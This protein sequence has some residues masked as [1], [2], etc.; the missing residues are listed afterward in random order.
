MIKV[1]C[2]Q[3]DRRYAVK[4]ALIGRRVK[5][6][7]C[8]TPI[9]ITENADSGLD[10]P[11]PNKSAG[12][13]AE[14]TS[15]L[16]GLAALEGTPAKR[17]QK[18]SHQVATALGPSRSTGLNNVFAL[19][20]LVPLPWKIGIL[21]LPVVCALALV[22]LPKLHDTWEQENGP[23]LV[24][25]HEAAKGLARAGEFDAATR[26]WEQLFEL[27]GDRTLSGDRM[28]VLLN[29]ARSA[30]ELA[31]AQK[32]EATRGPELLELSELA[33]AL[34]AE[35][36]FAEAQERCDA[37][38]AIL[39]PLGR[40][41]DGLADLSRRLE[42]VRTELAKT[43]TKALEDELETIVEHARIGV[44]EDRFA[45]A[46]EH[47]DQLDA[48]L[49]K[50]RVPAEVQ[51]RVQLGIEHTRSEL[52]GMALTHLHDLPNRQ[53]DAQ[54]RALAAARRPKAITTQNAPE[55]FETRFGESVREAKATKDKRDDAALAEV[56]LA[57]LNEGM[58][59]PRGARSGWFGLAGRTPPP[60][61]VVICENAYALGRSHV[62]GWPHAVEALRRLELLAPQRRLDCRLEAI[63]VAKKH[64]LGF[65]EGGPTSGQMIDLYLSLGSEHMS[66]RKPES[67]LEAFKEANRI[68]RQAGDGPFAL[69]T[70]RRT[71]ARAMIQDRQR[72]AE[73][74]EALDKDPI[75]Q[76]ALRELTTL[77]LFG[78][79][80]PQDALPYAQKLAD[81]SDHLELKKHASLA[82][83]GLSKLGFDELEAL[84]GWYTQRGTDKDNPNRVAMLMRAKL[85]HE[86]FLSVYL[87]RD[88]TRK[89]I[90]QAKRQ[91]ERHLVGLNVGMKLARRL[92]KKLRGGDP[93]MRDDPRI[94]LAIDRGVAYLYAV[95][96]QETH[97][98]KKA[99]ASDHTFG[100]YTALVAYALMMADEDPNDRPEL[101][102][103]IEWLFAMKMKG[104]YAVCFR[105]HLWETLPQ[106]KAAETV[107]RGDLQVLRQIENKQGTFH[108]Y[109]RRATSYDLS[110]TLAG[111]LAFWL[112]ETNGLKVSDLPWRRLV[113]HLAEYQNDD[114]GWGYQPYNPES[115]ATRGGMTSAALT[116]MLMALDQNHL[117]HYEDLQTEV[118]ASID[119]G[120][121]WLDE[122]F[123]P[124]HSPGGGPAN[125]YLATLQHV[126]LLSGRNTF[127]EQDW[128]ATGAEHLIGVQSTDGSWG[129]VAETAFAVVFLAR[130]GNFYDSHYDQYTSG[131]MTEDVKGGPT[132]MPA[133][134]KKKKTP[135]KESEADAPKDTPPG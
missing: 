43:W 10:S 39:R 16:D 12:A 81:A 29:E 56:L 23:R 15:F 109:L 36:R 48:A 87:Q 115:S 14:A 63:E 37:F 100:G 40:R 51:Q 110:T 135:P 34:L 130:G 122:N 5:C 67:A 73:L 112:G 69:I 102:R 117:K 58:A 82:A 19:W 57:S 64:Y 128:Y 72:I 41:T 3:C 78:K 55:V 101:R 88:E 46:L 91:V 103:A 92:L 4:E 98:D 116:I 11:A 118:E 50:V 123:V 62:S 59:S 76:V 125:Y 31:P 26:K 70:R 80:S 131:S 74:L 65:V 83:R 126:G 7:N 113:K 108:Y 133:P 107:I 79:D 121:Q 119:R 124:T 129:D 53:R 114:G 93:D 68:G 106:R 6:A 9:L 60:L 75:D 111:A 2:S 97:W 33:A 105:A 134:K 38:L 27:V 22:L 35:A 132:T 84:A 13:E 95:H 49:R 71:E 30:R 96:L 66:R 24:D 28:V 47:L 104:T 86:Q 85:Y 25:L 42:R 1:T 8:G 21:C 99:A 120:M 32:L 89:Q 77:F 18:A 44:A 20:A 90:V 17:K 45:V 52:E 127:N 54:R 94:Q 61:A